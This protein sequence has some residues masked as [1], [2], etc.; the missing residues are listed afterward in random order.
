MSSNSDASYILRLGGDIEARI[1][2]QR[3]LYVGVRR[4][5]TSGSKVFLAGK[6]DVFLGYGVIA[7]VQQ[8]EELDSRERE[9]CL[10]RNSCAK[11]FFSRLTRFVPPVPIKATSAALQNPMALH[12]SQLSE[13]EALEIESLANARITF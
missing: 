2:T 1:F 3:W 13:S 7:K 10:Q 4:G 5:W 9:F 11:I 8:I 6:V 12:G